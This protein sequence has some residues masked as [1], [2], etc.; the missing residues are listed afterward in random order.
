M[1]ANMLNT[2]SPWLKKWALLP[3]GEPIVTPGS[4]LLAVRQ[5]DGVPLML[6]VTLDAD[7][8]RGAEQMAWWK[9][10][11]AA[12]V[13]LHERGALLMERACGKQSLLHMAE[14]GEDDEASR[15]VCNVIAQL[16]ATPEV[17][18]AM[19]LPLP[20]WFASLLNNRQTDPLFSRCREV[21][22]QLLAAPQ[23]QV[24]LHGDMH[25]GNVLDFGERGWLAI[26]PKGLMG[27]RGF[28]YANLF[29]NP[30]LSTATNPARF[31]RQ[32][33][34]VVLETGMDRTRLLQWILA[35]AGLSAAWFLEDNEVALAAKVLK[36]ARLAA[37]SLESVTL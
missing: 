5:G 20:R 22:C 12:P 8:Q 24:V 4:Q 25:H 2:F 18:P 26:D 13:I 34:E 36:V 32:L 1:S 6:K 10:K 35:Y 16:H 27:E 28:D 31:L 14:N 3:E 15:I 33:E 17:P 19:L 9:G 11:G 29:C 7:E 21:A 23:E 37:D 30:E